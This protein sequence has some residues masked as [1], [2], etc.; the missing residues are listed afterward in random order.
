MSSPFPFVAPLAPQVRSAGLLHQFLAFGGPG[1]AVSVAGG[2]TAVVPQLQGDFSLNVANSLS[3][4]LMLQQGCVSVVF[5][6]S[7]VLMNSLRV[8]ENTTC[9]RQAAL[10]TLLLCR[11]CVVPLSNKMSDPE[12]VVPT[13]LQA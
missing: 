2:G 8:C 12:P 6:V 13:A 7:A 4:D 3:A 10:C 9:D 5:S 1:A 11:S